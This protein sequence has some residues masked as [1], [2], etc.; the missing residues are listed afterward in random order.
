[1]FYA[2][3]A[4]AVITGLGATNAIA[5]SAENPAGAFF[6]IAE[7][8]VGTTFVDVT[9]VLLL[10]SIFAAHLAIQNVATRYVYSL[11]KD[12]IMPR[13]LGVAHERHRSPH[14]SSIA[15]SVVMFSGTAALILLGLSAEQIYA[16][17]AGSAAFTIMLAMAVTSL[18][19]LVYFRRHRE[20]AVSFFRSTVAPA[21]ALLAL[22]TGV[23]LGMLHFPTLISG[24]RLLADS[25][26]AVSYGVFVAGIVTAVVLKKR[27]PD[28]YARIGRQEV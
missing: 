5:E 21:V 24:S 7:K 14:R 3:A 10:T 27:R 20:H 8:Y 18:A 2:I 11:A 23:V 9:S 12:G 15:T 19:I 22:G 28:V 17:F 26:L 1:M 6:S 16:W 13:W 25:I 4:W